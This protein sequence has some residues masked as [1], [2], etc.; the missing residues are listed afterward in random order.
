MKQGIGADIHIQWRFA[1]SLS[2]EASQQSL[3]SIGVQI[4]EVRGGQVRDEDDDGDDDEI[5]V[6][7]PVLQDDEREQRGQS[8]QQ[9]LPRHTVKPDAGVI[10]REKARP[11]A[12]RL[13]L[14]CCVAVGNA[15]EVDVG[16]GVGASQLEDEVAATACIFPA[17]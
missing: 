12:E 14:P 10:A 2:E 6:A 4:R 1:V 11:L 7:H 8:G 15:A 3:S 13:A 16:I 5:G 9:D 17:F